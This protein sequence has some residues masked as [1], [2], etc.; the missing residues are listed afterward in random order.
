[1]PNY[2]KAKIYKLVSENTDKIYI[3]STCNKL[4]IRASTHKARY[5][6]Y[7]AG[8][9]TYTTAFEILK[10]PDVEAVLIKKYKL[11]TVEQL[12]KKE[13]KWILKKRGKGIT[14]V[15]KNMPG[16]S[17]K[18]SQARY[19]KSV[20]GKVALAKAK[21]KFV[22]S[23]KMSTYSKSY[24]EKNKEKILENQKERYHEKKNFLNL[25]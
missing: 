12:R 5:K 1:M 19:H 21:K 10:E 6:R 17:L 25:L 24:Y 4:K 14:V 18:E 3:G 7:L 20:K 22:E 9:G 23:G 15:N 13:A 2:K 11:D 16:A 8:I